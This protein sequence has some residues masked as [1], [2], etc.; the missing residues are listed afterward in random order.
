MAA[1]SQQSPHW[2]RMSSINWYSHSRSR[3]VKRI[4]I[5]SAHTCSKFQRKD[6]AFTTTL[7][8][9]IVYCQ[10]K[11]S[12]PLVMYLVQVQSKKVWNS[13]CQGCAS[14]FHVTIMSK[15]LFLYEGLYSQHF[16]VANWSSEL[17]VRDKPCNAVEMCQRPHAS[18]SK[19]GC[20]GLRALALI[21]GT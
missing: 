13:H 2:E 18:V 5:Y 1:Q 8:L 10:D 21:S 17:F 4:G 14:Y 15:T 3:R 20:S 6:K 7:K 9:N 19:V 12:V 11:N 16:S